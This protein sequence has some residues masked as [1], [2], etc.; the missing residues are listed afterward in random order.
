MLETNSEARKRRSNYP[1]GKLRIF[2]TKNWRLRQRTSENDILLY[3]GRQLQ[4][5]MKE[6]EV[7]IYKH[8]DLVRIYDAYFSLNISVCMIRQARIMNLLL[9]K[10]VTYFAA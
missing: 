3:I 9:Y 6:G 5:L 8:D 2:Y 7:E 10:S 4:S 1:S